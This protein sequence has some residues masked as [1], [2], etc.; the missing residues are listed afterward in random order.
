MRKTKKAAEKQES[1]EKQ[2]WSAADK[3]RSI[4]LQKEFTAQLEEEKR[5]KAAILESLRK[6]RIS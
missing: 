3:L 2:L 4:A 5:L 1:L 6:V